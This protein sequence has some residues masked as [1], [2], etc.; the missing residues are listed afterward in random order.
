MVKFTKKKCVI[1]LLE[2]KTLEKARLLTWRITCS[3]FN[4]TYDVKTA[5]IYSFPCGEV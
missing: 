4:A 5:K 3:S 2:P 1:K